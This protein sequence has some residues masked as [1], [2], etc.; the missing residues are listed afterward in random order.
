[1]YVRISTL[2]DGTSGGLEVMLNFIN[3][4]WDLNMSTYAYSYL[5]HT[6]RNLGPPRTHVW[7]HAT[8]HLARHAVAMG[9]QCMP[10]GR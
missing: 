2:M 7:G 4:S 6:Y 1:M 10:A 5:S 8:A 3:I 9:Y